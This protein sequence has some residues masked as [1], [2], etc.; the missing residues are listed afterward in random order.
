MT[1]AREALMRL[2]AHVPADIAT[3]DGQAHRED[4]THAEGSIEVTELGQTEGPWV[5]VDFADEQ[6]FAIWKVTGLIYRVDENGAVEEEP[7]AGIP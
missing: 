1:P 7:Y 6:R 3:I 2:L 5:C 4:R